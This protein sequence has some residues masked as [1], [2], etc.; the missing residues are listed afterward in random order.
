MR[1][2]TLL[3][4]LAI[5]CVG[6]V[7]LAAQGREPSSTI[8]SDR[9]GIGSGAYVL[10]PGESQIEAGAGIAS[11]REVLQLGQGLFRIGL[12]AIELQAILNSFQTQLD[13][14]ASGFQDFGIGAKARIVEKD[15]TRL[16]FLA[17]LLL[18][19]G[20]EA[21]TVGEAV[22]GASL[23]YATPLTTALG[24]SVNGR[25]SIGF[26]QGDG[27]FTLIITPGLAIP[28]DSGLAVYGGYAGFYGSGS[29]YHWLEGGVTLA[30]G[31]ET[32]LDANAGWTVD[33]DDYFVGLGLAW[34]L[35]R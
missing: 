27:L 2:P 8:M 25:Y 28:G 35:S 18:P 32:Q 1:L 34:R 33:G 24:L 13:G 12:P 3:L 19:T 10:A 31:T 4:F 14:G 23:L 15:G 5:G 29:P 17:S 30:L 16:A 22:M 21:F 9:P 11:P 20:A 7:T 6:P 26:E